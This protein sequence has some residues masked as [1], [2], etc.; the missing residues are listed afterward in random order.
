MEQEL[1]VAQL[2]QQNF[3]PKELP[4]LGGWEVAAYYRAARAVGGD[5]YDF[6]E[7]PEG[8][9]GLVI[10]DVTDK[11]V[12]AAMVMAA[13][14][15]VLRASAQRLIDPGTVLA[16]VNDNLCPDI[17]ENM[18]VT[19][20]YGVLD[21]ASGHLRYANAGHNLPLVS[22]GG[23][24]SDLRATGMPLGL[25]P[26]MSYEERETTLPQ[27]ATV[28]LYS[29]GIVEAHDDSREMFGTDRVVEL[30]GQGGDCPTVIGEL[31]GSLDRFTGEELEQEDDITLVVLRRG[32]GGPASAGELAAFTLASEPGNEREAMRLV[33]A[34]AAPFG[35]APERL[36]RLKT[37]TAEATMN[38]M[39]HGNGYRRDLDVEVR[40]S[41]DADSLTVAISDH[42]GARPL[43][44]AATPDIDAKLEGR[45]SPRGWGLF[46]IERMVDEVRQSGDGD[47][48]TVELVMHL[49]GG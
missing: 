33:A 2:I 10:G 12:P 37:A 13:T 42:G 25:M 19:C 16:R 17:P 29:D 1:A 5:F 40:V 18:F 48:H 21:P 30:L 20:F 39:E 43:A 32:V 15:S 31:L 8:R 28:L 46:L 11:G 14:R 6:I 34:A 36:E 26:G 22:A 23:Q 49:R 44:P 47:R 35:L 41:A 4:Q 3:L 9:L 45:Q 24:S 7:L 27:G 38:A